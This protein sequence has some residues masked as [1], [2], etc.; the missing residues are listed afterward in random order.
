[1]LVAGAE[2]RQLIRQ[3]SRC[4]GLIRLHVRTATKGHW[5]D[6]RRA[7]CECRCDEYGSARH[8]EIGIAVTTRAIQSERRLAQNAYAEIVRAASLDSA[9]PIGAIAAVRWQFIGKG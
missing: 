4:I 9:V 1:M 3:F 8:G 2:P 6:A 7:V 5:L